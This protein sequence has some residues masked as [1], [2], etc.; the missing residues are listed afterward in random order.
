MSLICAPTSL[1]NTDPD[2]TSRVQLYT[3]STKPA[4]S[5]QSELALALRCRVLFPAPEA[6]SGG[7]ATLLM[8]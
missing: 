6:R 1:L 7:S 4:E 3:N 5:A 8:R 2:G